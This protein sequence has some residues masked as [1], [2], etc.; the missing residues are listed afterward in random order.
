MAKMTPSVHYSSVD[1]GWVDSPIT[2]QFPVIHYLLRNRLRT[3]REGADTALW[4]AIAE[5][6]L[7]YESGTF[8]LVRRHLRTII[9]FDIG[10]DPSECYHFILGRA[11]V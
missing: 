2:R 11:K 9:D 10:I 7:Y 6:G 4:I 8:Y 5:M 1:P 3:A